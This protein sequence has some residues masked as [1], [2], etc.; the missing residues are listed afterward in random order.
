MLYEDVFRDNFA[1]L[2]KAV[3]YRIADI[4]PKVAE[5]R[6]KYHIPSC[7]NRVPSPDEYDLCLKEGKEAMSQFRKAHSNSL[8]SEFVHEVEKIRRSLGLG[9]EW[10][11]SFYRHILTGILIPPPFSVYSEVDT[12]NNVLIFELNRHTTR[13]DLLQAWDS[14]EKERV[15]LFRKSKPRHVSRKDLAKLAVVKKLEE[16]KLNEGL[17]DLEV[18]SHLAPDVELE[19]MAKTDKKRGKLAQKEPGEIQKGSDRLDPT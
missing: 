4:E 14:H 15:E 5:L 1:R 9:R 13:D 12:E 8:P 10:N 19:D 17:S 18:A 6:A 3:L 16:A 11:S 7:K 2:E